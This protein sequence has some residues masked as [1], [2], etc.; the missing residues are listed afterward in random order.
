MENV[1]TTVS[2]T[3]TRQKKT[4]VPLNGNGARVQGGVCTS[5]VTLSAHTGDNSDVFPKF[6]I[7][8]SPKGAKIAD[9][10][11]GLGVFWRN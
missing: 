2:Q 4:T 10:T 8:T 3:S 9:V 1:K 5:D 6:W 7:S 11:Y